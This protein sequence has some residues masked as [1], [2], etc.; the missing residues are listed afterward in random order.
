MGY[1][2]APASINMVLLGLVDMVD[3]PLDELQI[4]FLRHLK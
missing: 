1:R 2:D 4:S 3:D